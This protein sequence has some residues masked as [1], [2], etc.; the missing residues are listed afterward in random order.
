MKILNKLKPYFTKKNIIISSIILSLILGYYFYSSR[1]PSYVGDTTVIIKQT[2]INI[3][4]LTNV[5]NTKTNKKIDS[6]NNVINSLQ[7][8]NTN[9]KTDIIN[10]QN[11]AKIKVDYVDKLND[12]EL[13]QFFSDRYN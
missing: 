7:I 4:S 9:L 6:L 10:I 12:V 5:I 11:D 13:Q 3:D 8:K 2:Q 1:N